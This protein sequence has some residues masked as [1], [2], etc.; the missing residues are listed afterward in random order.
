[1]TKPSKP[2][3]P[4]NP[5]G[6]SKHS[7]T[8][9]SSETAKR[10]FSKYFKQNFWANSDGSSG[11]NSAY[12]STHLL[13]ANLE[14]MFIKYNI[15]SIFDS[16]CGDANLFKYIFKNPKL[17]K[18]NYTGLD[19]VEDMI[20]QNKKFFKDSSN[21][22]DN[23]KMSFICDDVTQYDIPKV[24]LIISRDVAHYLP[25]DLIKL[26][27]TK[28]LESG[29]KY[30]LITHNLASAL[31]ANCATEIGIFR[32]VNLLYSPFNFPE[33]VE[34]IQEDT[35]YKA[36]ALWRIADLKLSDVDF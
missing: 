5:L 8:T 33:P 22:N 24:D 20:E 14:K 31:S 30:L 6:P 15:Q 13:R 11:P 2:S 29:S 16:G 35:E 1:M 27:L 25:N 34:V 18:I 19:C 32:P 10:V 7:E 17:T 12:D 21:F 9:E 28:V 4:S 26:F 23:S 36:M 3:K